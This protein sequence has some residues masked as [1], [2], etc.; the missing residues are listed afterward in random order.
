VAG[1]PRISFAVLQAGALHLPRLPPRLCFDWKRCIR[2]GECSCQR[3]PPLPD[4]AAFQVVLFAQ[5]RCTR[6]Q[7]L[8]SHLP[9]SPVPAVRVGL[10]PRRSPSGVECK[11]ERRVSA[12]LIHRGFVRSDP[13]L[14]PLEGAPAESWGCE[15]VGSWEYNPTTNSLVF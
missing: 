4:T 1:K 11:A 7:P 13:D 14:G 10:V 3:L 12:P 5:A 8:S 9:L 6:L 2:G 15:D